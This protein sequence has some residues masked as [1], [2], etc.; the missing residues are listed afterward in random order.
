MRYSVRVVQWC[1]VRGGQYSGTGAYCGWCAGSGTSVSGSVVHRCSVGSTIVPGLG[2]GGIQH[3]GSGGAQRMCTAGTSL[4]GV[5][6]LSA[7]LGSGEAVGGHPVEGAAVGYQ[8][9][10][11]SSGEYQQWAVLQC[12]GTSV[13]CSSGEHRYL[14]EAP[15]IRNLVRPNSA[16]PYLAQTL[17]GTLHSRMR[18][19]GRQ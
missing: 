16:N 5:Q 13:G 6:G 7:W 2:S 14:R 11:C 3:L 9:G 8:C 18:L 10:W 19:I 1:R 12:A 4:G 17:S 15:R